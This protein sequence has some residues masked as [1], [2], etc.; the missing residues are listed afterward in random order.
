MAQLLF[1]C[2]YPQPGELS[3]ELDKFRDEA[4]DMV[5]RFLAGE[6]DFGIT[7]AEYHGHAVTGLAVG[8][9]NDK[10][11]G[12]ILAIPVKLHDA[13]PHGRIVATERHHAAHI[14]QQTP[15]AC[16]L[17]LQ[18]AVLAFAFGIPNLSAC[19]VAR[20]FCFHI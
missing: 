20:L 15:L 2:L 17:R 16:I 13:A 1:T 12:V 11:I 4:A 5:K 14:I 3:A 18:M 19:R 10:N 7:V 6:S 9:Y 8:L